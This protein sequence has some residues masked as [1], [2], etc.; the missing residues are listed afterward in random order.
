MRIGEA[1]IGGVHVTLNNQQMPNHNMQ[2]QQKMV[3]LAAWHMLTQ[4][5]KEAI[6]MNETPE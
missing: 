6:T 5:V 1:A 4:S 3:T 2:H